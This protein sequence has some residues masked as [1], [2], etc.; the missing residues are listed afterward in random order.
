MKILVLNAGSSSLK[1]KLYEM[2]EGE[3]VAK[4]A[5]E[6]IGEKESE[7]HIFYD[8]NRYLCR[9]RLE[10]HRESLRRL[11]S[12]LSAL[13]I[14]KNFGD[15]EGVGHRVVHGGEDFGEPVLVDENVREGIRRLIPL[16]PL[17][18]RA[19][20]DVMETLCAL[21]PGLPQAAVFDTAFHRSM[22]PEAYR[23]AVPEEWYREYRVRR[24]GFHGISHFYVSREFARLKGISPGEADLIILHLGNG[25]SACAVR[26][27]RSIDTSMGMTP[28]AGLVMGTRSGDVDP[29]VLFYMNKYGKRRPEE[30]D[31]ELNY[32]SGLKGIGGDNDMRNILRKKGEGDEAAGLAFEVFMHRLVEYVGA[33]AALLGDPHAIVFTGG[34]GEHS[35][36]VREE[37]C[38]RLGILGIDLDIERNESIETKGRPIHASGSRTEV[39]VIPTDEEG[40]IAEETWKLVSAARR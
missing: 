5:V 39:W 35:A 3:V 17:H 2:P 15:I 24:Y 26:G 18:N 6:R 1:F 4:G 12:L 22:P 33:Y 20:L 34:I 32:E 16:A 7:I 19:S 14:V 37:L 23:Y 9:E 30:L 25:A 21:L 40:V 28:L 8:E 13:E 10:N 11:S 38:R 29:A 36:E 27:G 31:H